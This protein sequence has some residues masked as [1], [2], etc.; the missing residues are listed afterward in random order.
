MKSLQKCVFCKVLD[1]NADDDLLINAVTQGMTL[2]M[3]GS[4]CRCL[5][6]T[7]CVAHL[8]K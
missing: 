5:G 3:Q 1:K 7:L 2:M 4:L 6:W 8:N